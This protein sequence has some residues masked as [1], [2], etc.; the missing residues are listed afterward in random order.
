MSLR[1]IAGFAS[2]LVL[3][4][5]AGSVSAVQVGI[6]NGLG[7]S[8]FDMTFSG[9]SQSNSGYGLAGVDIPALTTTTGI[10]TGFL[11]I[12]TPAAGWV[13]QNMLIDT[14]SGYPGSSTMFN[15]GNAPGLDVS[16]LSA[17]A[18]Y[19]TSPTT[20]FSPGSPTTFSVGNLEYNAQG[21]NSVLALPPAPPI[22]PVIPWLVGGVTNW[23]QQAFRTSV[24]QD[25][26]QCGPGSLANSLQYLEDEYGLNVP[27]DHIPGINGLDNDGNA[28]ESLVGEIDQTM[29][30]T[31][32]QTV[33]D[34]NFMKGKLDYIAGNGL[35]DDLN[36]K[37]WG[38]TFV[39]GNQTSTNGNVGSQDQQA[40]I[41]LIDWII[42]EINDGEDV[43]LALGG[44]ISH[45][46]NVTDAGKTLGVPWISW[47]H[48][49]KQ[50]FDDN[51]TAG[52]TSD[53]KTAL[54]GGTSWFDGGIGWSPIVNDELVFFLQ[55]AKLD[56]AVSE[57][58]V[59]EPASLILLMSGMALCTLRRREKGRRRIAG[60]GQIRRY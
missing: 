12:F 6:G 29:M 7:F 46:V 53:D 16:T 9:A 14:A 17:Y 33:S 21:R 36:I 22:T 24:E 56:F 1:T 44:T 50:G 58:P 49:A 23:I 13:V 10:S 42:K 37:H 51:G 55:G 31:P 60:D 26:N 4:S 40:G 34:A 27:H 45:W 59:P 8:Q 25:T 11:N 41:S 3:T 38:G 35:G 39:P 54:N 52:D 20:S 5:I 43:E 28:D 18:D 19:S 30:R 48:D 47:T 32:H 2:I 57:S 15:L